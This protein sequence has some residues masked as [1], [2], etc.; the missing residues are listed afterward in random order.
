MTAAE[1]GIALDCFEPLLA[2]SA[3]QRWRVRR[4]H[5]GVGANRARPQTDPKGR[6]RVCHDPGP[7]RQTNA[8]AEGQQTDGVGEAHCANGAF[9]CRR[10]LEAWCG[11]RPRLVPKTLVDLRKIAERHIRCFSATPGA[12]TVGPLWGPPFRS[13]VSALHHLDKHGRKS[14]PAAT[15]VPQC[16][17]KLLKI[18]HLR[19]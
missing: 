2:V 9:S 11:S 6:T 13:A 10:W 1:E 15:P 4:Q 5:G 8:G 14:P 18:K 17:G 19:P 7:R 16:P 12:A 3:K